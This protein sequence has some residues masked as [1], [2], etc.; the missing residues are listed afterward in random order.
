MFLTSKYQIS[1][2]EIKTYYMAIGVVYEVEGQAYDVLTLYLSSD[3]LAFIEL[4]KLL[5][6]IFDTSKF[7]LGGHR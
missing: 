3:R 1:W 5:D 2:I 7:A 6:D 4:P